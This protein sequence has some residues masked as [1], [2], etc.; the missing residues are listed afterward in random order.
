MATPARTWLLLPAGLSL[1]AG[2]DAGL[3]LLGVPA[4]VGSGRLPDVHGVLMVLGFLG[5]LISLER[6]V[7]LRQGW[8]Y[9]APA[10]LGA[11]GL[12][13][14]SPLPRAVGAVLLIDGCAALVAVLTTLWR[15]QRDDMTAVEVLAAVCAL[16]AALLWTRLEISALLPWLVAFIVLT[17]S[18]ERVELARILLPG[19]APRTLVGMAV[20]FVAA[21]AGALLAPAIGARVMGLAL[22]AMAAWL[23]TVDVARRTIRGTGQARLSAVSMLAAYVWLTVAGLTWVSGGPPTTTAAYDI[24]VHGVFLGFAMSMVVAHAPVILPAV[25]RRPLPHR[26]IAWLP[27]VVLHAGLLVRVAG[28]V[29]GHGGMWQAGGVV[30]VVALLLLP[31]SVIASLLLPAPS[32]ARLATP[33]RNAS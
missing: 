4:P 22:V 23:G 25:I 32:R 17:I 14:A 8:A 12:A 10:L 7:A 11:G 28:D 31:A 18:A 9:A 6:A 29:S 30:T 3:L 1:L 5:T 19:T 26:P 20:L 2:L 13:L 16:C 27:L 15:R 33:A 21:S 24:V